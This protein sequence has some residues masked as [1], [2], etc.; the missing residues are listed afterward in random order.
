MKTTQELNETMREL[1]L[2]RVGRRKVLDYYNTDE[3]N[4]FRVI[5]LV[6]RY[7]VFALNNDL[8]KM[9]LSP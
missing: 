7:S 2:F 5:P 3:T 9:F 1:D 8:S 6:V 4:Y